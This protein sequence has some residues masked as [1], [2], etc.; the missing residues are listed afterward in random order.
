MSLFKTWLAIEKQSKTQIAAI[1]ELNNACDTKYSKT[2]PSTM[3]DRG[4][5]LERVPT[6]V[7]RYMMTIVLKSKFE[8]MVENEI[9]ELVNNLT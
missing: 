4:Y 9:N 7:R 2:W 1:N 3:K 6:P 5:S 8:N